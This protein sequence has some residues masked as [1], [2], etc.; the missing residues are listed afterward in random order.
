MPGW[1]AGWQAA[2]LP[3]PSDC[4]VQAKAGDEDIVNAV[5]G[6]S[7]GM[8]NNCPPCVATK[9]WELGVWRQY[10]EIAQGQQAFM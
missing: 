3:P 6:Q 1:L 9:Y 4:P 7:V 8:S 2:T 5:F 10:T